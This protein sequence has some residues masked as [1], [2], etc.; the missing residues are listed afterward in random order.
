MNKFLASILV[1]VFLV[2][3][4]PATAEASFWDWIFSQRETENAEKTQRI[5]EK[6]ERKEM[7]R[8]QAETKREKKEQKFWDRFLNSDRGEA[9]PRPQT[10]VET[11]LDG[12]LEIFEDLSYANTS[13][14]QKLDLYVPVNSTNL[15][16]VVWIHGG[17]FTGGDKANKPKIEVLK[18]IANDGYAVA[19]IN[20]RFIQESMWPAQLYD[21][22]AAIRWLRASADQFGFDANKIA[23]IGG[24]AGANLASLLGTTG[25][26]QS[27]EGTEGT[28]LSHSS[29]V[30]AVIDL[31][32]VS[33]AIPPTGTTDYENISRKITKATGCQNIESCPELESFGA[34]NY[35]T[36]DDP[37]FFIIHA[38]DDPI[39]P[40]SQSNAFQE[41]LIEN[42]IPVEYLQDES[43]I[44]GANL[45]D[46]FSGYIL[47]FL[48][49]YLRKSPNTPP[50]Q[51]T[52]QQTYDVRVISN[53]HVAT[54][55]GFY[56][57][58]NLYLPE[59]YDGKIPVVVWTHGGGV[60]P[61]PMDKFPATNE[62]AEMGFAVA[63]ID[64]R[65]TSVTTD[66]LA[67]IHDV[68]AA[69]RWLRAHADEYNLDSENFAA[70]GSSTGGML[71]AL[72]G[73]SGDVEA[74]E[75]NVGGNLFVSSQVQ[76]VVDLYGATD[77][78]ANLDD[79]GN[80][81]KE[82]RKQIS[83]FGCSALECPNELQEVSAMT[84]VSNDDP[85]FLILHGGQD[86]GVPV[87]Q[88]ERLL[89]G[90]TQ[91]GVAA[92]LIVDDRYGHD[93]GI[94]Y[95]P[96]NFTKVI[97]FLNK[98]LKEISSETTIGSPTTS[99]PTAVS[100]NNQQYSQ[101]KNKKIQPLRPQPINENPKASIHTDFSVFYHPQTEELLNIFLPE[102]NGP[103][104]MMIS[105]NSNGAKPNVPQQY[106]FLRENGIAVA[107]VGIRYF[108]E[109]ILFPTPIEDAKAAI[110][111][112]RVH[113]AEFGIDPNRIGVYGSS[114]NGMLA[115]FLGTTGDETQFDVGTNL[116]VSSKVQM[117]LNLS[118]HTDMTNFYKD[119][120][121][122][123]D[124]TMSWETYENKTPRY[125]GCDPNLLN[126]TGCLQVETTASAL[127]Y[128]S[129]GD[130]SE[131]LV[132]GT[133]DHLVPEIQMT[134]F[135]SELQEAN[136]PTEYLLVPVAGHGVA[137]Q[138]T[139]THKQQIVDFIN[140]NWSQLIENI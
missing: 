110:R 51:T 24:S 57:T 41:V 95:E 13:D 131:F 34:I 26:I 139:N 140:A 43:D 86:F 44:H 53:L 37:P 65:P 133:D 38:Q 20:Y 32:G 16:L 134:R 4:S 35:V 19:S 137:N 61:T 31:S 14:S 40:I 56:L 3:S 22:K 69:V 80:A 21:A 6:L 92:E 52:E 108:E 120:I 111:Y 90:L 17:S 101:N 47:D 113:A 107:S 11:Y 70:L 58:M 96:E 83:F 85:P 76:A 78:I 81:Q 68:K 8:K 23:V 121:N 72:L 46:P 73:T 15:P 116:N 130:A 119:G 103:F 112:L 93:Q 64:Y 27:L 98:H 25:G 74:L 115:S 122:D 42:G 71:S 75:G 94:L 39:V 67:K 138:L 102:G 50:V 2:G 132:L 100:M 125:L 30:S 49:E 9:A 79:I 117:V 18:E 128:V 114:K 124:V 7:I 105:I 59:N 126:G 45:L 54:I 123:P 36:S 87:K 77:L 127:T 5:E 129:V 63:K 1:S 106:E 12:Q 88:S 97:N 136:I 55:D 33:G 89:N 84:Y 60:T 91:V 29:E 48:N 135:Y 62:I 118:G 99:S 66:H 10:N 82:I 109:E 28:Y 104:P